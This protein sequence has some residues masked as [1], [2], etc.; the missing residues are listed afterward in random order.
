V[1]VSQGHSGSDVSSIALDAASVYWTTPDA[2][3]AVFRAAKGGGMP[4]IL[5]DGQ[6]NAAHVAVDDARVYGAATGTFGDEVR[7][8][9]K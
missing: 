9:A 4:E 3:G 1:A 5:G 2:G 7:A 6:A 8:V